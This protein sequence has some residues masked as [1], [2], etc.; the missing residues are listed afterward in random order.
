[1]ETIAID[2]TDIAFRAIGEGTPILM[3]H[4]G[5]LDH[6]HMVSEMEPAF[7]TGCGWRRIY[8]DLPGHGLTAVPDTCASFDGV[9]DL[10]IAFADAVIGAQ[11]FAVAGMSAGGH[12]VRGLVHKCPDRL[13]GVMINAAPF[14][15]DYAKR[16]LPA[17]IDIYE[18]AGFAAAAGD[19]LE[20]MR[21]MQPIR[22]M[23]YADWHTAYFKT[24]FAARDIAYSDHIWQPEHYNYSFPLTP[25]QPTFDA[26]SLI[27]AGRQDIVAGYR[28]A[29]PHIDDYPRATFAVLDAA[30]HMLEPA[31]PAL[32]QALVQDWLARMRMDEARP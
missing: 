10:V 25:V 13:R 15:I 23:R 9:L 7:D 26:P 27:I 29:V 1:M 11:S 30:G 8:P 3:L 19:G 2:R 20:R 22:S 14:E 6:R 4:G 12:L 5:Y 31:R 32:F 24:A 28:D 21:N 16:D 18:D 17:Q